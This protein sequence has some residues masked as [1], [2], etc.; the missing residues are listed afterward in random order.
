MSLDSEVRIRTCCKLV[1]TSESDTSMDNDSPTHSEAVAAAID[2]LDRHIAGLNAG[3]AAALVQT[4]HFPHYRL[5]GGRMQILGAAGHVSAGLPHPRRRRLAPQRLGLSQDDRG[6]A[7]QG[8]PRRAVQPLSRR[9]IGARDLS[10]HLGGDAHRRTLGRAVAVELRGLTKG[11]LRRR[12]RRRSVLRAPSLALCLRMFFSEIGS[13]PRVEPVK[14]E[15][16]IFPVPGAS[17]SIQL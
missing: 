16:G 9:R 15:G 6:G 8:T 1:R 10:L 7:G 2:V 14:P 11:R 5:A 13:H 3:D 12:L 17:D 4:L